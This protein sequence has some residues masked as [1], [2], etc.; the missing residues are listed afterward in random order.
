[1][2]DNLDLSLRIRA[3]V[4]GLRN[5]EG[6]T[7][8]LEQLARQANKPLPDPTDDMDTGARSA[9][10][11]MAR[12]RTQVVQLA[13]ALGVGKLATSLVQT[14]AQF[15]KFGAQLRTIEGSSEAAEQSLDWI[16]EF[17]KKTPYDLE[18]VT[19][20]FVSMKAYGIDPTDGA[21][22]TLGNT[23]AA[24]GKPLQQAV[25]ALADAMTGEYERLKEFGI[26]ATTEGDQVTFRY[27]QN[28]QEMAKTAQKNSQAM[29]QDTLQAI[30]NERYAGGITTMQDSWMGMTSNLGDLWTG[31][32][33]EIADA[34]AFDALKDVL[35]ELL[36]EVNR[37]SKSGELKQWA[38]GVSDALVAL[39]NGMVS[40]T[41]F[42]AENADTITELVAVYGVYRL[43]TSKVVAGTLA[44]AKA[45]TTLNAATVATGAGVVKLSATMRNIGWAAIAV[46]AYQVTTGILEMAEAWE[47]AAEAMK[48]HR[49][50]TA[51][52]GA[53]MAET[54]ARISKETGVLIRDQDGL[55]KAVADG[56][57]AID[58]AT[59]K[60]R[61][62]SEAMADT[63]EA[64]EIAAPAMEEYKARLFDT[65]EAAQK[66]AQHM[67][68]SASATQEAADTQLSAASV[69]ERFEERLKAQE[70]ALNQETAQ[71]REARSEQASIEQEF[72]DLIKKITQPEID[73]VGLGDVFS[74]INQAAAAASSGQN[75]LA[76]ETAREGGQL[77]EK[78]SE[79]GSETAGTLKYLGERLKAVASE[80]SGN[81]VQAEGADVTGAEAAVNALK[82]QLAGLESDFAS[83]GT[84]AA[85]AYINAMQQVFDQTTL[86]PPAAPA[87]DPAGSRQRPSYRREQNLFTDGTHFDREIERRGPK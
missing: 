27:I 36:D 17:A 9:A 43:M 71:L 6:L 45:M 79:K 20:A 74:K 57:L 73:D 15:E 33:R 7:D 60:W 5:V 2:A 59:G 18:Q 56:V 84:A 80:A 25:E 50:N 12:L 22:E 46:Q 66:F 87:P 13:A 28:G 48:E 30:W 78:L 4:E 29:I 32:Q 68:S 61:L 67:L 11:S 86:K 85:Q 75:D 19:Q 23:A 42:M 10:D 58:K 40:L 38:K 24:M 34:G 64:A 47:D 63:G 51:E 65:A 54:Y 14:A 55:R 3:L 83:S 70:A 21:L 31:F 37:L 35:R 49:A 44:M 81:K 69:A 1:M 16:T 8:E 72:D 39:I 76:I 62:A 26:R 52:H 77:L 53:E 41:K 82:G